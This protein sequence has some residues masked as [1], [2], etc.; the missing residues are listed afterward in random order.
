MRLERREV[1]R[2]GLELGLVFGGVLLLA[3]ALGTAWLQFGLPRPICYFHEW[4]GVPCPTCGST[5]L[6]GALL[7]GDLAAALAWNPLVFMTLAGVLTWGVAAGARRLLGL[8]AW[9]LRLEPRERN[10]LRLG[11]VAVIVAG[12]SYLIW[13]GV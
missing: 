12:W 3:A 4:T 10:G 1:T 7:R 6:L 5:R 11:A 9:R 13:R 8:P 2:E